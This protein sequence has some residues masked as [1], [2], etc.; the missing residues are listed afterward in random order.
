MYDDF[1][2]VCFQLFLPD[3]LVQSKDDKTFLLLHV[4]SNWCIEEKV[5][6]NL[7]SVFHKNWKDTEKLINF[8]RLRYH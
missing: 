7:P 5:Y 8:K 2:S 6:F 3:I 1:F 4:A